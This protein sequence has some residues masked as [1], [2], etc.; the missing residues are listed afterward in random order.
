MIVVVKLNNNRKECKS[1]NKLLLSCNMIM[2]YKSPSINKNSL[3]Y[4]EQG[5][6]LMITG[7]DF[8]SPIDRVIIG[9]TLNCNDPNLFYPTTNNTSSIEY[10]EMM[11]INVTTYG[12][13]GGSKV[14][15][16]SIPGETF[17]ARN[18]FPNSPSILVI[19]IS[20]LFSIH[21]F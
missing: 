1:I 9:D 17:S 12:K 2:Y 14:S 4:P 7:D 18:I 20:L 15:K 5:G 16:F 8:Y 10:G 13:S 21:I 3:I 11:F 6:I 19:V